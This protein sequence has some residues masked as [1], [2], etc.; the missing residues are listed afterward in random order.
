MRAAAVQGG[1]AADAGIDILM[2]CGETGAQG[3][4]QHIGVGSPAACVVVHA[5]DTVAETDDV[6]RLPLLQQGD[7]WQ[8]LA[9]ALAEMLL[10][11]A[12][13]SANEKLAA[14]C[15]RTELF[16]NLFSRDRMSLESFPSET[17]L[18]VANCQILA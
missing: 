15:A 5:G 4:S 12:R 13:Q 8:G 18:S 16:T 11:D 3:D 9:G 17:A 10:D 2:A 7:R 1:V 14:R 6:Q